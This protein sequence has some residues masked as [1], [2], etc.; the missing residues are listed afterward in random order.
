MEWKGASRGVRGGGG[1][2]GRTP[3]TASALGPQGRTCASAGATAGGERTPGA[4]RASPATSGG[5]AWGRAAVRGVRALWPPEEAAEVPPEATGRRS[6]S[7]QRRRV[8]QFGGG[9]KTPV[10]TP[11]TLGL[12]WPSSVRRWAARAERVPPRP[13]PSRGS[14]THTLRTGGGGGGPGARCSPKPPPLV[15]TSSLPGR[16]RAARRANPDR[17]PPPRP[18]QHPHTWPQLGPL[19]PHGAHTL[20]KRKDSRTPEV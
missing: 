7:G 16:A 12:F 17:L 13:L 5:L 6:H 9:A 10:P 4:P 15:P 3:G 14:P 8:E 1:P 18:W 2:R 19:A 20:S 11:P